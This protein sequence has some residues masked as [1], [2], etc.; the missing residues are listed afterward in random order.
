[1]D[2]SG[3]SEVGEEKVGEQKTLQIHLAGSCG[4][5]DCTKYIQRSYNVFDVETKTIG[6]VEWAAGDSEDKAIFELDNI[7]ARM[8]SYGEPPPYGD[9]AYQALGAKYN[10]GV[11]YLTTL[12]EARLG[13]YDGSDVLIYV[14]VGVE[15]SKKYSLDHKR[16]EWER[17]HGRDSERSSEFISRSVLGD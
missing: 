6:T 2:L 12:L 10:D 9:R 14:G 4:F 1:M 7:Y 15:H 17:V 11:F 16:C 5:D 3:P 13:K 8:R